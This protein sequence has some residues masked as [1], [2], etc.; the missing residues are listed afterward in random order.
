MPKVIDLPE[1]DF[2]DI[3][4]ANDLVHVHLVGHD[5]NGEKDVK[6]PLEDIYDFG[7]ERIGAR[8][9]KS[10]AGTVGGN[11]WRTVDW[12]QTVFDTHNFVDVGGTGF[13]I[14][15]D[16][17]YLVYAGV[18]QITDNEGETRQECRLLVNGSSL[19]GSHYAEDYKSN[20]AENQT[21]VDCLVFQAL[22]EDDLVEFTILFADAQ[23]HSTSTGSY[24]QMSIYRIG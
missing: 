16:G 22:A 24:T 12:E 5:K 13:V 3:D 19:V 11:I 9:Y 18:R 14:P 10:S 21:T 6:V 15:F 2:G 7:E 4:T 23:T 20:G 1:L 8:L 17:V